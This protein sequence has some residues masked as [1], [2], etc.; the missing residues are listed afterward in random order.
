MTE[1]SQNKLSEKTINA[2]GDDVFQAIKSR[3][4]CIIGCGGIGANFAEMLART[5][6]DKIHLIDG[7]I[8]EESNLNRVFCFSRCDIGQYKVQV[9]RRKLR[10]I[11]PKIQGED[12][13]FHFREIPKYCDAEA[14]AKIQHARDLVCQ[15]DTNIVGIFCDNNKIRI[16]LEAFCKEKRKNHISAAIRIDPDGWDCEAFFE[17]GWRMETPPERANEE[18]YAHSAS[19]AFIIM[20]CTSVAFSMMLANLNVRFGEKSKFY[21]YK[22]NLQKFHPSKRN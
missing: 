16:S 2:L 13:A 18:G 1:T 19:L 17:C 22:K 9:I 5:G 12:V 3:T 7:D 11:N 15:R 10:Q 21:R 20:E 14:K 4:Y 8:V 6:A